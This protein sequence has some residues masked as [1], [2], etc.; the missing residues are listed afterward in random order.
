MRYQ[1][2]VEIIYNNFPWPMSTEKQK[3][4]I[5]IAAQ[6]VLDARGNH[7]DC[8]LADLYDTLTMPRDLIIAHQK[9]DNAVMKAYKKKW[10]DE[11]D[12]VSDLLKLWQLNELV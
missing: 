10:K 7:P 12:I 2:S 5:E 8:T 9:L 1:Y 11:N 4:D 6:A 3:T